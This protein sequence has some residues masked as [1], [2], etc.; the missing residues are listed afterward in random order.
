MNEA[1]RDRALPPGDAAHSDRAD[2]AD[3]ADL[4]VLNA[5]ADFG[6]EVRVDDLG[7]LVHEDQRL[8]VV[9]AAAL[10]RIRL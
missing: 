3:D 9:Q 2:D 8:E 7:V 4:G 5:V 6:A 10:S 1:Q